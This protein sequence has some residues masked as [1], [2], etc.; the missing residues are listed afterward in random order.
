MLNGLKEL[1]A[2]RK[3]NAAIN[4]ILNEIFPIYGER[5]N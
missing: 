4:I 1:N 5:V 3:I 2:F